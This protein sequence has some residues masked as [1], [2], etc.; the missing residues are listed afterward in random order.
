MVAHDRT[1]EKKQF[2]DRNQFRCPASKRRVLNSG[3][4]MPGPDDIR[5]EWKIA[6]SPHNKDSSEEEN[7]FVTPVECFSKSTERL[8]KADRSTTVQNKGKQKTLFSS[9]KKVQQ[10]GKSSKRSRENE[11]LCFLVMQHTFK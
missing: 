10:N 9:A 4:A 2:V 8:S 7:D 5:N 1:G 11:V 6:G 3:G